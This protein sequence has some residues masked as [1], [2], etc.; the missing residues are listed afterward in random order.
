MSDVRAST[1]LVLDIR[2]DA[3]VHQQLEVVGVLL[4]A[5]VR[6]IDRM[7][8]TSAELRDGPRAAGSFG[9]RLLLRRATACSPAAVR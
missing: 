2:H 6:R 3:D 4:D 5:A 9:T 7:W 8:N 1:R